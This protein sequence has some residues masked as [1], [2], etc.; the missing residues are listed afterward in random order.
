MIIFFGRSNPVK[1]KNY[2]LLF[3]KMIS[4][5][6]PIY[7]EEAIIEELFNR[8][9]QALAS[10]TNDFE[11]ICVND[12]SKD[13]SEAK[14]TAAHNKD[15]RFKIISLSRNFGHQAAILAGLSYTKGDY[16][17]IM[18]GDLQDPPELFQKFLEKIKQGYDVIYAVRTKRKESFLKKAVYWLYY[19]LLTNIS[20]CNIPPDSGDFS[21]VTRKV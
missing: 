7:N 18:D 15:K 5:V 8:T 20:E 4:I 2:Y 3:D 16:I 11:I 21:M 10:F 1:D 9:I 13:Q 14:L 6:I 12:G 19:R 17:G